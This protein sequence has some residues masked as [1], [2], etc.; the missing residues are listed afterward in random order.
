MQIGG[1]WV[2]QVACPERL[3]CPNAENRIWIVIG[4]ALMKLKS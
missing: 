4:I 2:G 1:A 3:G